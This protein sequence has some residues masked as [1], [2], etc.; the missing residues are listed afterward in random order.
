MSQH[1]FISIDREANIAICSR[2]QVVLP[3]LLNISM[4]TCFQ[5]LGTLIKPVL[6]SGGV[7][8][9]L[10]LHLSHLVRLVIKLGLS[11][12]YKPRIVP[13]S[14]KVMN[15]QAMHPYEVHDIQEI[16]EA[17]INLKEDYVSKRVLVNHQCQVEEPISDEV[18]HAGSQG[19]RCSSFR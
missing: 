19:T 12:A 15:P 4:I 14:H 16:D 18:E 3:I 8:R 6:I 9:D 1:L 7:P 17:E 5:Q 13:R 10:M 2:L 11:I